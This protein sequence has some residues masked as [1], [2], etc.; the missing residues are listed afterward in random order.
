MTKIAFIGFGEAGSLIAAGLKDA[1]A[2]LTGAYDILIDAPEPPALLLS[3][4]DEIG[5]ALARTP[6]EAVAGADIVISAVTTKKTLDAARGAARH[7]SPGQLW[8]DLNSTSPAIKRDAARVIEASNADFVE[9]AVMDLVPPHGHKVPMLLAGAKAALAVDLLH[10]LGMDVTA[11]GE[12]IGA[13]S[14]VKMVR[15]VFMKGFTAILLESLVAAAELNAEDEVLKSLQVTFPGL[16]WKELAD[17]Y[18]PRLIQHAGRQ[19]GE[20]ISVAETLET[21][22]IEPI[23]AQATR[24][25]L[26]WLA[27]KQL[28]TRDDLPEGYNALLGVIRD[29]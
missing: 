14:S 27:D 26:Q 22:G 5:V 9:A 6:A 1:G 2:G 25:R 4:A 18:L 24:Q 3:R 13:A 21:L 20:M 10:R 12:E 15:S 7:L 16:D 17:Y 19:A 29:N 8:L 28:N 23:T 11:I